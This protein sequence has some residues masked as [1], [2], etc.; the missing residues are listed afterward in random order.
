MLGIAASK[1]QVA[2]HTYFTSCAIPP[3]PPEPVL[4]SKFPFLLWF[5]NVRVDGNGAALSS[6]PF[7]RQA[8]TGTAHSRHRLT[9]LTTGDL[10]PHLWLFPSPCFSFYS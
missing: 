1:W 7:A 6:P 4:R 3:F 5:L 2:L 8:V 9:V 10:V